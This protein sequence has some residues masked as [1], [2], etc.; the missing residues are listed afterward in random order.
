LDG[1][2]LLGGTLLFGAGFGTL[3]NTTLLLMME[4]VPKTE[5]G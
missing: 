5:Y 2:A 4:R 3:Q 1:F